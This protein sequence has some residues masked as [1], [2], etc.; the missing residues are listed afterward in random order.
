MTIRLAR[1]TAALAAVTSST[2]F[3]AAIA[4]AGTGTYSG[5]LYNQV[6]QKSSHNS[7]ERIESVGDQIVYHRVHSIEF[8]LHAT[9]AAGDFAV[10]H[11]TDST[12]NRCRTLSGCLRNVMSE[13]DINPNHE[14]ITIFIDLKDSFT[15]GHDRATLDTVLANWLGSANKPPAQ[16]VADC[17]GATTLQAAVRGT[18]RWPSIAE[19]KG[20]FFVV[21]AGGS[22][23]YASTAAVAT[24]PARQAYVAGDWATQST[25]S[26]RIFFNH[27]GVDAAQAK[28]IFNAGF[29]SRDY[30][31]NDSTSFAAAKANSVHLLATDK[32]N[33]H[34]DTWAETHNTNLWPFECITGTCP[35]TAEAQP[36]GISLLVNTEDIDG[37]TDSGF[38]FRDIGP[39]TGNTD[40][41]GGYTYW[42]ADIHQSES[43]VGGQMT[44]GCLMARSSRTSATAPYFAVCTTGDDNQP[45]IQWRT[46]TGSGWGTTSYTAEQLGVNSEGVTYFRLRCKTTSTTNETCDGWLSPNNSTWYQIG[47]SVTFSTQLKYQGIAASSHGTGEPRKFFFEHVREQLP[48]SAWAAFTTASGAMN[49]L[50]GSVYSWSVFDGLGTTSQP[51][52]N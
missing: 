22:G 31:L 5:P 3:V 39:T 21:I 10:F 48:G 40:V 51:G 18:C 8:D 37:N 47:S 50:V 15:T 35:T 45:R 9:G 42:E 49:N 26:F 20:R 7:Y 25:D 38:F 30:N 14:V 52:P 16:L 32:V 23:Q 36:N 28:A 24:D 27:D 17:P 34:Q 2:L 12:Y 1:S 6:R 19:M 29:I 43:H 33:Y 46:A 13:H 4:S 44:K 41:S 11:D